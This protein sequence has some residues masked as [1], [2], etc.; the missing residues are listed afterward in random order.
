[1]RSSAQRRATRALGVDAEPNGHGWIYE[2]FVLTD[3]AP[4]G[5]RVNTHTLTASIPAGGRGV[6]AATW[7]AI[8]R[9]VVREQAGF[10]FAGV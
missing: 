10:F 7:L 9:D 1:M 3:S 4:G 2:K 5:W 6:V 8:P